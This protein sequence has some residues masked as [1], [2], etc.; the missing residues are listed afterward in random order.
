MTRTGGCFVFVLNKCFSGT[1]PTG[2]R[3][4]FES[5]LN[6]TSST[7]TERDSS[8]AFCCSFFIIFLFDKKSPLPDREREDPVVSINGR[9]KNGQSVVFC[10]LSRPRHLTRAYGPNK[11][12]R[13][14]LSVSQVPRQPKK[15][16]PRYSTVLSL[17]FVSLY[18]CSI[19]SVTLFL[20]RKRRLWL[21]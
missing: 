6:K 3:T 7:K 16:K 5:L 11:F 12:G 2:E 18:F 8:N 17:G 9:P 1:S 21:L 13:K 15:S 10:R 4:L 14:G 19:C 20:E